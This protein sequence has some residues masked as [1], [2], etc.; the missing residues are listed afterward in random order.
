MNV[1]SWD[2]SRAYNFLTK[3]APKSVVVEYLEFI[4]SNWGETVS[5][6][7]NALVLHYKDIVVSKE[8]EESL[9]QSSEDGQKGIVSV[10]RLST[11]G[12]L[13][14]FLETSQHFR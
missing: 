2:R 11:L 14:N 10:K 7:H 4:I 8:P 12:K 6:F 13:R 3:N 1:E 5:F 9:S